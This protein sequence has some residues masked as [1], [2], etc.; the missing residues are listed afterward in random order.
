MQ[1][2]DYFVNVLS[3]N[4]SL[5]NNFLLLAFFFFFVYIIWS[6]SK[7]KKNPLNWSDMLID[8]KTNKLSL[9]KVAQFWGVGLS[10]WIAIYFA[11]K[12]PADKVSDMYAYIFGIWLAFLLGS[13]SVSSVL[14]TKD[15]T[16]ELKEETL[17]P[18]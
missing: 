11:Q 5:L 17:P 8:T 10:S 16:T 12:V 9:T 1:N 3:T 14:K 7:D 2:F 4:V 18:Q 15:T 6:A 13:Y